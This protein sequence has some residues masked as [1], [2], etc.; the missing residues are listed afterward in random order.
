MKK[1]STP[2]SAPVR[3]NP[4]EA[5]FFNIRVLIS[6]LVILAGVFLALLSFGAFSLQAQQSRT[7]ITHSADPLV[8]AGFD[9][10]RIS[11]LGID[12]QENLRA[13]AIMI[14]CGRAQGG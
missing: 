4:G 12:K 5:G 3:R 13:G 9:C 2:Q 10:S 8:P 1:I 11:G 14:A 6:L 7:I